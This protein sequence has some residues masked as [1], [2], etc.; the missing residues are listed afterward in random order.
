LPFSPFNVVQLYEYRHLK[1]NR[2]RCGTGRR[3]ALAQSHEMVLITANQKD[4]P[5]PEINFYSLP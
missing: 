4:F 5:M 3:A 1:R 2:S